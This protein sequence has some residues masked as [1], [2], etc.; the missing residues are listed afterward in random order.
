LHRITATTV[1]V[2]ILLEVP[3]AA[4]LAWLWLGQAPSSGSWPGLALLPI[5][6]AIVVVGGHRAATERP[7]EAVGAPDRTPEG[8]AP[9]ADASAGPD[10]QPP[11]R[12][13]P[14]R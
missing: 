14:R 13:M 1:S 9:A 10:P 8:L 5:G 11:R 7:G 4:V 6:V 2:L 12:Q 3:G